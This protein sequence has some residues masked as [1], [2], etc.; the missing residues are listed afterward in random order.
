[1][2]QAAKRRLLDFEPFG[3]PRDV[4]LLSYDDEIPEM[5]RFHGQKPMLLK[6]CKSHQP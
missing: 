2:D 6:V 3:S 1:L 5:P 4:A